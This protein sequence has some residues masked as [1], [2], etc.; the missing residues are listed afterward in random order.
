MNDIIDSSN[1]YNS[2]FITGRNKI[3]ENI[4]ILIYRENPVLFD[5]LDY[6]NDKIFNEPLLFAYFNADGKGATLE[7]LLLGYI[8]IAKWPKSIEAMTDKNGWLYLPKIGWLKTVL[9]N[10]K[11]KLKK[12]PESV[13]GLSV[14][15]ENNKVPF[16]FEQLLKVD[17]TSFEIINRQHPL[18][19][20][21][22][23]DS[24]HR[25]VSVEI[26]NIT[27]V[28]KKNLTKAFSLI[29]K[30]VPEFYSLLEE[31]ISKVVIFNDQSVKRNSFATLS[32]HGCA[33]FN[34]FQAEY[35]EIFFVEDIAH[36]CGHVIFNNMI[37]GN[38]NIF[39]VP[40]ET[41]IKEKGFHGLIINW[42]EKRS[43]FV[44]FHALFT[45]YTITLCLR[46]IIIKGDLTA[47][48]KN[49]ALGRLAFC[50]R[51]FGNDIELL[52][53]VD[54]EGKSLYFTEAGLDLYRPLE[55]LYK[56]TQQ[57]WGTSIK[58]VNLFWQPYNFSNKNFHKANPVK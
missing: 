11:V 34:S 35:D 27:G 39:K 20:P 5:L 43:L 24:K 8:E 29:C 55:D 28:Q 45:Y 52:G 2:T 37:H 48:Q 36:Q 47:S 51:K 53:K 32:V 21:H 13:I 49:E 12:D 22:Y 15:V 10:K 46:E 56:K 25:I 30:C 58:S 26:E 18:L 44:A 14:F 19:A 23:F 42:L 1:W 17:N 54:K 33:F 16:S 6:D 31:A 4:R 7:Q 41:I 57:E 50:F 38:T 40:A 3:L 9:Y